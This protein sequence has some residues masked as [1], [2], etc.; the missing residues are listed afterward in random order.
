M[1]IKKIK[2]K[3]KKFEDFYGQDLLNFDLIDEA[4]NK[5]KLKEILEEHREWM[6]HQNIDAI[7]DLE[8]FIR[9]IGLDTL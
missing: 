7:Q 3:M 2:E 5:A 1:T 6:E 4:K 8:N 9:E